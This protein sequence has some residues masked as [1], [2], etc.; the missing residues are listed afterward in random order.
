MCPFAFGSETLKKRK[1]SPR[2][3]LVAPRYLVGE[4]GAAWASHCC[5]SFDLQPSTFT[6]PHAGAPR[7]NNFLTLHQPFASSRSFEAL[8]SVANIC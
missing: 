4:A 7:R 1:I 8:D 5:L 3:E 6:F 2:E